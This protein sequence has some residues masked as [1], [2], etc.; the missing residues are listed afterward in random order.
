MLNKMSEVIER[1]IKNKNGHWTRIK[2]H[3]SPT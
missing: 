3:K 2:R 1:K